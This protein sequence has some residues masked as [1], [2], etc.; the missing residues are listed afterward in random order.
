MSVQASVWA[1]NVRGLPT[2]LKLTLLAVADACNADGYG[3]PGQQ[4]LAD[5]IECSD[6]QIRRNLQELTA[7]GLLNVIIRPGKGDGRSSNAYQLNLATIHGVAAPGNRTSTTEATGH[8]GPGQPDIYDRSNRTCATEAT[9]HLGQ[10]NRTSGVGQPD[11]AMSYEPLEEPS[12]RTADTHRA[13]RAPG[14]SSVTRSVSEPEGFTRFW[15]AWP[16]NQRKRGRQGARAVWV[17]QHLEDLAEMI[18]ADVLM[19]ARLDEQWARGYAPMPQTYLRGARW[20]DELGAPLATGQPSPTLRG[21]AALEDL[22][23]Q[24]PIPGSATPSFPVFSG[25]RP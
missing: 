5:Q 1:W 4:R 18:V 10:G 22:K 2:H 20:E 24:F 17:A 15:D 23:C 14:G 19:R 21:I 11:I 6:R 3:Y 25:S 7:R 16:A 13:L 9:G 12:D 8:V